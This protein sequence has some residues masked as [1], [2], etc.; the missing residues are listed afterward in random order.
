MACERDERPPSLGSGFNVES[1]YRRRLGW[2]V[3]NQNH[4]PL[5]ISRRYSLKESTT[6]SPP[7]IFRLFNL[8]ETKLIA[9]I[10]KTETYRPY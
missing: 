8:C 2:I 6:E 7:F 1:L 9:K 4:E 10:Y 3:G 5:S